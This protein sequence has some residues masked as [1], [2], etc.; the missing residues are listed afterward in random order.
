MVKKFD[1]VKKYPKQE[2]EIK[3]SNEIFAQLWE[4]FAVWVMGKYIC[5]LSRLRMYDEAITGKLG[6]EVWVCQICEG[7]AG[8]RASE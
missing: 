2:L 3:Y 7:F 4:K 8:R 6:E 1:Y 5:R